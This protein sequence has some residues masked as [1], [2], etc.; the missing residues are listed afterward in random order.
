[1]QR[2]KDAG[3]PDCIVPPAEVVK[4]TVPS[5]NDGETVEPGLA[6]HLSNRDNSRTATAMQLSGETL[7]RMN[8]DRIAY[9]NADIL[10]GGAWGLKERLPDQ[11]W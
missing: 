11:D 5:L 8:G 2:W 6:V 1:M 10:E 4:V 7:R 3:R 9:F